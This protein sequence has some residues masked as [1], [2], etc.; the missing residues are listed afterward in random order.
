[1]FN[2]SKREENF[3]SFPGQSIDLTKIGQYNDNFR[4]K[5]HSTFVKDEIAY[6]AFDYGG[7]VIVNVSDPTNPTFLWRFYDRGVCKRDLYCGKLCICC[8]RN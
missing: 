6:L 7:L 8:S 5:G 2:H 4:G 3:S 1:M